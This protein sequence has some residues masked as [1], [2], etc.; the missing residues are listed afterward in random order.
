V[1]SFEVLIGAGCG[2]IGL[3]G[4]GY[5]VDVAEDRLFEGFVLI[6]FLRRLFAD[7]V[8]VADFDD[9]RLDAEGA[10]ACLEWFD[11]GRFLALG[12]K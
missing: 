3:V 7:N 2:F 5:K 4:V 9:V 12:S 11:G 10:T 6:V 8:A 1:D